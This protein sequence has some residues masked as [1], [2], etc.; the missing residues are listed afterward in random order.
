MVYRISDR[1]KERKGERRR[2]RVELRRERDGEKKRGGE[3]KDL[4]RTAHESQGEFPLY[5][6]EAVDKAHLQPPI[7]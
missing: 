1:Q 5:K 6:D 4:C 2:A 3:T 7:Y